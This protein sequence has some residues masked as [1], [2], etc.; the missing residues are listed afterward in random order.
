MDGPGIVATTLSWPSI[1][2]RFGN[3]WQ[4]HSRSDHHSKAACWG[5]LFDLLTES[6]LL[7]QHAS[8]GKVAFG[9]NHEMSDFHTK[10]KKNLDL[11]VCRPGT[12]DS[13]PAPDAQLRW[14]RR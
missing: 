14:P 4:Y 13:V 8:A 9:V 7:R 3:V 11:V 1:P 12:P 5:V 2:D 10:R 6:A